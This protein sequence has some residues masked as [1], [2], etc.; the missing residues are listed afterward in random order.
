MGSAKI[1]IASGDEFRAAWDFFPREK[2]FPAAGS[3]R[4]ELRTTGDGR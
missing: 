1:T 2:K 4:R 3:F